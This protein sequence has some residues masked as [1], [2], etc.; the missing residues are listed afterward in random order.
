MSEVS[1]K[2][3]NV[4]LSHSHEDAKWVEELACRLEDSGF[5]IWLDKWVLIP[6]KSWQQAMAR[7]LDK[8][9]CCAVCVSAKTPQGWFRE[10]IERALEL[11][12]RNLDFRVVPVL[13]PDASRS[14]IPEFLSLRTWADFRDGED[15][16]YTFHVLVQGIK[17]DSIGRW[18][19][20]ETDKQQKGVETYCEKIKELKNFEAVGLSKEVKIEFERLILKKWL[21]EGL[22]NGAK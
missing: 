22:E 12:T 3:F 6:G 4:F 13:L 10:E 7:G 15:E 17:G 16:K 2:Q 14:S 8:A 11:Q 20:L 1:T 5:R 18:P 19:P 21:E 9:E